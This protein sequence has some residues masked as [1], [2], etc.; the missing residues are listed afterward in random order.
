MKNYSQNRNTPSRSFYVNELKKGGKN[1]KKSNY[2]LD[3]LERKLEDLLSYS[4]KFFHPFFN[5][6]EY[7]A[8][9]N[10]SKPSN[11]LDDD[12]DQTIDKYLPKW[13][14]SIISL[15]ARFYNKIIGNKTINDFVVKT[16]SR[17]KYLKN[18]IINKLNLK[19]IKFFTLKSSP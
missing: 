4:F 7:E 15:V 6:D 13:I 3:F 14:I 2:Q 5:D 10:Y 16:K 11:N 9:K 19:T 1:L 18:S 12:F 8:N 17:Y